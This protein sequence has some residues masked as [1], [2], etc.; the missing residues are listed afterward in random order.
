MTWNIYFLKLWKNLVWRIMDIFL[1]ISTEQW[2]FLSI[3]R[4]FQS[5]LNSFSRNIP[6]QARRNQL[7]FNNIC[8]TDKQTDIIRTSQ[9]VCREYCRYIIPEI[10]F[11]KSMQI[12]FSAFLNIPIYSHNISQC[13][14]FV[15]SSAF[16]QIH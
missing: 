7:P 8:D 9:Q 15:K 14:N 4:K 10:N 12:S 3:Q 11:N 6:K 16:H 13:T 1:W 2:I 5:R